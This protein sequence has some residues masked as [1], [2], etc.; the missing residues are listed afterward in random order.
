MCPD[1]W[2]ARDRPREVLQALVGVTIYV[3]DDNSGYGVGS[4]Y[5]CAKA[6]AGIRTTV[7]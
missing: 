1:F 2:I 7:L 3:P 6:I 4:A 5:E